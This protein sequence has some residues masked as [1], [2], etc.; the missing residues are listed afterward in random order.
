[1]NNIIFLKLLQFSKKLG[2]KKK[3]FSLI[4]TFLDLI[5]KESGA[6]KAIL[7]LDEK[8][9][10]MF[11]EGNHPYLSFKNLKNTNKFIFS[12]KPHV[13]FGDDSYFFFNEIKNCSFFP[14]KSEKNNVAIIYLEN[15]N[16]DDETLRLLNLLC[17]QSAI[18][19]E[20]VLLLESM[21]DKIRERAIQLEASK[22]D[23]VELNQL[24]KKINS[25]NSFHNVMEKVI[26]YIEKRFGFKYFTFGKLSDDKRYGNQILLKAPNYCSD[27]Q[28]E[29]F[30]NTKY[31]LNRD[32]VFFR[33]YLNGNNIKVYYVDDNLRL[34][35]EEKNF[36]N[37]VEAKTFLLA[38]GSYSDNSLYFFG[39]YSDMCLDLSTEEIS[40]MSLLSENLVNLYC[41]IK[42]N[43][44]IK[45]SIKISEAA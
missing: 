6:S 45:A 2:S 29:E 38:P 9:Y 37:M 24:F 15:I 28:I 44:E 23:I 32:S 10:P 21:E 19:F 36:I 16:N 27:K 33:N 39:L 3:I 7:F 5:R 8:C 18:Y 12:N 42:T 41:S 1:M 13:T 25:M 4:E 14:L 31:I 11:E 30:Y 20:N 22:K 17:T 26:V 34:S 35:K 43:N 40:I